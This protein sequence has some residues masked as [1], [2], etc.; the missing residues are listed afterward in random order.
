ME[1]LISSNTGTISDSMYNAIIGLVLMWG[2]GV[3][4]LIL[5]N[6]PVETILAIPSWMIIVGYFV[7]A[8]SGQIIYSSSDKPLFS[9]IGYNMIVVPVGVLITPFLASFDQAVVVDAFFNMLLI[10]GAMMLAGA[11]KPKLF[12]S[13]IGMATIVLFGMILSQL[14][15]IFILGEP[16]GVW[17]DYGIIIIM[18]IFIAF[19]WAKGIEKERTLDNAIDTG[20]DIYLPMI[21]ILLHLLGAKRD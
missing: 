21:N 17:Y 3:N 8:I 10:S 15:S 1:K 11:L 5:D 12:E 18:S 9:F 14:F 19:Y 16:L 6:V 4:F 13:I 2:F 20:A 7:L